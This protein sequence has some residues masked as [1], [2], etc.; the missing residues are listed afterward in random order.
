MAFYALAM[1]QIAL[2]LAADDEVYEDL[3]TKFFEHFAAITRGAS[4]E[5]GLWDD[6]T[7]SS[8]TRWHATDGARVPLRVKSLVGVIP[9][10][11]DR[12][13]DP[14]EQARPARVL[15]K[16]FAAFMARR[17]IADLSDERLGF[18]ERPRARPAAR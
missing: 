11:R 17:G 12:G 16:R 13:A 18:T 1:L 7:A 9:L 5:Q 8:T 4:H 3:V 15:R 14:G 2:R 10:L 6:E